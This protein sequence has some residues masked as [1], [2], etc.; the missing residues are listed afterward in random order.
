M[1]ASTQV[2]TDSGT[3]ISNG[4]TAATAAASIAAAGPI[5]DYI[6]NCKLLQE[7]FYEAKQLLALIISATDAADPSLATLQNI[8]LTL[9]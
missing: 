8:Q 4:P 7:K 5:N 1:V 3:V 2:I 6:G 9:S